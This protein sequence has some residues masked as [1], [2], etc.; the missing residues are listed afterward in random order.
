M[1]DSDPENEPVMEPRP[2][3]QKQAKPLK[4]TQS[5]DADSH[6]TTQEGESKKDWGSLLLRMKPDAPKNARKKA[7]RKQTVPPKKVYSDGT[8]SGSG[9]SHSVR[10][11]WLPREEW[12]A[13]R[14]KEEEGEGGF[15][16]RVHGYWLTRSR[17]LVYRCPDGRELPATGADSF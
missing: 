6:Q 16:I 13:K 11:A 12:L 10:K 9:D 4:A 17:G 1:L 7:M 2:V 3:V 14:K 5:N 15:D 8:P